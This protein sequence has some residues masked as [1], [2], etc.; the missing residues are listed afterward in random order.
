MSDIRAS[1]ATLEDGTGA[2]VAVTKSVAGDVASAK[3]G[4]TVFGFKDSSGNIV[5]PQLDAQG[6]LPVTNDGA[7]TKLSAQ[8]SL[9]AGSATMVDVTGAT[10]TL[11]ASKT[12]DQIVVT[13]SCFRDAVF[14][15]I[16]SDNGVATIIGK[17]RTGSGQYSYRWDGAGQ[18]FVAGAT[19]A[20]LL[21]IQAQ[22][23]ST[24]SEFD[25][26][27]SVIQTN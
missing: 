13:I 11:V 16:K 15:I 19:G 22:N 5:L 18:S 17:C 2:G 6:R 9:A 24:L 3:V 20:Q 12:Y 1:F 10:I 4:P 23:I 7:G 8:G 25:A 14:N 27:V 21:K 26:E